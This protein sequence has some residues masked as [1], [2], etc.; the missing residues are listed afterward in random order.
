MKIS[1][2]TIACASAIIISA[3]T[4]C[5]GGGSDGPTPPGPTVR[6]DSASAS[7]GAS[8]GSVTTPNGEAGVQIPAGVLGSQAT[9]T[10]AKLPAPS[11]PNQGPL[12]T[13]LNQYGPFYQVSISPANAQLGDSVRV[14]VC[15]VTDPGSTFYAPEAT[16]SRLRLAHTVG[17]TTEILEP[18]GV[19]DFL[20]CTNVTADADRINPNAS[21]LSRTLA[22]IGQ[23]ARGLFSPRPAYA[24]H[25][26]L[27]GKVKSFSPFGAVDPLTGFLLSSEFSITATSTEDDFGSAAFDGTNYLVTLE[28]RNAQ[29]LSEINLQFVSATGALVGNRIVLPA[30]NVGSSRV[31]FDGTNYLVVWSTNGANPPA[32]GQFVSPSGALVGGVFTVAG[33]VGIAE[34]TS[35]VFGGGTYFMSFTRPVGSSGG[36]FQYNTFGR[37]IS[38]SGITGPQL[39]LTTAITGSGLNNVAFDGTN[40]LTV[41]SDGTSVKGRFVSPAGV[42][43]AEV[44]I[45]PSGNFAFLTA[46]GFNGTNYLVTVPSGSTSHDAV[47]QLLSPAGARV[48][49]VITITNVPNADEFPAAVWATGGDFIVS[50]IDSLDVVGKT[51]TKARFV[52]GAGTVRGPSFSLASPANGKVVIGYVVGFASG[53]YFTIL[54]RGVQNLVSPEDTGLW[55]QSDIWGVQFTATIPPP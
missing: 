39:N 10:V 12:P 43:G 25:G 9:I 34:P 35:L 45:I 38:T 37:V 46:V 16:H 18:V 8:G 51:A 21:R 26:G 48:G 55:T 53:K 13:T 33:G 44:A 17:S 20:R 11:A 49:G 24:A 14:G 1:A 2:C 36:D 15:Q 32:R 22:A 27:G 7:I 50:Y 6:Q 52:S 30:T 4:A 42:I 41:Y 5:G 3:I 19:T 40:F 23:S 31:A 29:G 47:G 54:R 28:P